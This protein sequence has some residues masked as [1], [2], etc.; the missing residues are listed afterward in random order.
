[1]FQL[2]PFFSLHNITLFFLVLGRMAGI[3]SAIPLFGGERVPMNIKVMVIFSLALVCFPVL[4]LSH[5]TLPSDYL[6][7]FLLVI[8]EALIGVTLGLVAQ[9]V[10]GA[11]EFCGQVIGM[12]MGFSMST[13]FDPT[14]GQVPLMAMFQTLV[15]TLLFLTFGAHH[16]FIRAMVDSYTLIPLGGWHMSGSMLHYLVTIT[17]GIFILGIKLA[18][19]VMVSLLATTV[20]LGVMARSFP[21]MNIFVVSMPLNIAIG[22]LVLGLSLLVFIHTVEISFGTMAL[23]IKTIFKI[24]SQGS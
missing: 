18:A 15:A 7:L 3:F 6:S 17:S 24:I 11:V 20:V 21:Q 23:Q 2:P 9:S 14:M 4:K 5:V 8:E 16:L 22:F 13:L 1:M 12:Q 19:P 10:F